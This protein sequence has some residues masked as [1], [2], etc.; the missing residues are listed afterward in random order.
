MNDQIRIMIELQRFWDNILKSRGE[1]EKSEKLL[2]SWDEKVFD[3]KNE[4]SNLQGEKRNL[5][6]T[7]N[8]KEIELSE[9]DDKISKLE[10]RKNVLKTEREIKALENELEKAN[11]DKNSLEEEL[12]ILFDSLDESEFNLKQFNTE[13]QE[14]VKQAEE[15]TRILRERIIGFNKTVEENQKRFE[16]MIKQ[17]SADNKSRFLKLRESSNGKAI[18]VLLDDIC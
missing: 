16:E 1:T 8:Q 7:I 14:I 15:D 3:K 2:L 11:S 9:K 13:L 4:I 12:I 17:L 10:D 6:K 5:L 18:V